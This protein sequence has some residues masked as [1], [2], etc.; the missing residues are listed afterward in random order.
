MKIVKMQLI[1]LTKGPDLSQI[2]FYSTPWHPGKVLI[3]FF[4]TG[5][6]TDCINELNFINLTDFLLMSMTKN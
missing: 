3:S 5:K 2:K 4:I 6:T 1:I